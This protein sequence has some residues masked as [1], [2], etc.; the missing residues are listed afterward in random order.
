MIAE[1]VLHRLG[2]CPECRCVLTRESIRPG[3]F[4]CP[5]CGKY[6]RP[7]RR[8]SYLSLRGLSCG[9]VAVLAAKFRTGFPWSFLFFV[10]GFY[11]LLVLFLWDLIVF[12]MF[13]PTKFEPVSSPFQTLGIDKS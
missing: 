3:P 4:N 12:T 13:P 6:I 10:I 8:G 11:A 1:F 7:V 9:I 5:G 2:E